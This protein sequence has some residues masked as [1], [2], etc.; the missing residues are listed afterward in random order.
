MVL[1]GFP[2]D[3]SLLPPPQLTFFF[4][5]INFILLTF[6]LF[7]HYFYHLLFW[8]S[9]LLHLSVISLPSI[10]FFY[11]LFSNTGVIL[12]CDSSVLQPTLGL[13]N[14]PWTDKSPETSFFRN[15]IRS[16]TQWKEIC[17]SLIQCPISRLLSFASVASSPS[18]DVSSIPE[19]VAQKEQDQTP[20]TECQTL[21]KVKQDIQQW[22]FQDLQNC[23]LF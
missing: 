8:F 14:N 1:P 5:K 22:L 18:C 16:K 4:Y 6:Q 11:F 19:A 3:L 2:S 12:P 21:L 13:H 20:R 10:L 7:S 15:Q 23:I 9:V 17:W